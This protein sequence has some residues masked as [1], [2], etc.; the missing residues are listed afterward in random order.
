M[1]E[2]RRPKLPPVAL[3]ASLGVLCG[4]VIA[5]LS[6]QNSRSLIEQ[7][8]DRT[9]AALARGLVVALSDQL[10]VRD[11]AGLESRLLQAMAD[12]SLASALVTDTS[13]RVLVHLQRDRPQAEP[14]LLFEPPQIPIPATGQ[15]AGSSTGEL[16]TR[17]TAIEAGEPV[18]W[19]RLR[20]WPTQ[21]DAVL[22]LLARQYLLLGA[23]AAALLGT[24]LGSG[25]RQIRR[26]AEQREHRLHEEKAELERKALTDHLTGV[27][28]RRGLEL[29]L[30]RT[31]ENPERRRQ[32]Q[33][34]VC[35][36][37]LDDFKPVNDV[38]GHAIGDQLLQAVSR[39]LRGILRD[40][41]LLGRFGGDEFI[42]VFQ[43]CGDAALALQL[44][45]RITTELSTTFRIEDLQVR[46]GAS[47]GVALDVDAP[48]ASLAALLERAD[49]VMYQAKET[50]K[51]HV[52][53]APGCGILDSSRVSDRVDRLPH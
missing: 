12:G 53:L 11:Y 22:D 52:A 44:A 4:V 13:G 51:G 8:Q 20:T 25:Y 3:V 1:T 23:L 40:G 46:I 6:Y 18:G 26:Q 28:N 37:D 31:L 15:A 45:R 14:G 49:Q 10:V 27:Y 38:Y 43:H 36:I 21:T 48:E 30:L 41:D 42:V 17:W 19:L 5:G 7:S 33:L 35:M 29:E 32:A 47:V 39:R 2:P 50:A 9:R 16:T 34:A 24:I